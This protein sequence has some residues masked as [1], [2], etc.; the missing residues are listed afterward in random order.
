MSLR[1]KV[2]STRASRFALSSPGTLQ[3]RVLSSPVGGACRSN[4]GFVC[5]ITTELESV[6]FCAGEGSCGDIDVSGTGEAAFQRSVL[7]L[8]SECS[9]EFLVLGLLNPDSGY[10]FFMTRTTPLSYPSPSTPY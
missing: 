4:L 9:Y 7:F 8:N 5:L 6:K 2:E 3:T 10:S 1:V